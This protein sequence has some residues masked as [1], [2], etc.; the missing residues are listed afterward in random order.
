MIN[1]R[2]IFRKT[3]KTTSKPPRDIRS[4]VENKK[5][6]VKGKKNID[7]AVKKVVKDYGKTLKMLEFK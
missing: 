5:L 3:Q 6:S 4:F 2:K 7:R 1:I